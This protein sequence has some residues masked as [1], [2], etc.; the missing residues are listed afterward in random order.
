MSEGADTP[1]VVP[2]ALKRSAIPK[3]ITAVALSLLALL[4]LG[5]ATLRYGVM[6]PQA[7][8]LIE[9]R[10]DGLKIGRFGRLKIEGLSGDIWRDARAARLTIRDEKGV[11]LEARNVHVSW[12]Y[13]ELLRRRF[14]AQLIEADSV[15]ILR[16]PTLAPKGKDRGLP[17]SFHIDQVRS[18]LT[19]EPAFSYTRGVYD[20]RLA[21]DLGRGGGRSGKLSA[22]SVL[23]PGDHLE[24]DF[25]MGGTGPLKLVADAEEARGGALAGAIGLS[26][27]QPF[28]LDVRADGTASQG[29]FTAR[30]TSGAV[31][32]LVAS[33]AWNP[34]GGEASRPAHRVAADDRPGR[35]VRRRRS[36]R[37]HR[38]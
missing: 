26:P 17:V 32:P 36:V 33:G 37:D 38:P 5:V 22:K 30:A 27:G 6:L 13:L 12:H 1:P 2:A 19:M 25:A 24:L 8:I 16:R 28:R 10:T 7:R 11:W 35:A 29:R 21:L 20:V 15:R 3:A 34:Q 4:L 18:R 23:H 9:A 14:D 31:T